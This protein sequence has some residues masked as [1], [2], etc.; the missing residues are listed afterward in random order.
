MGVQIDGAGTGCVGPAGG[1]GKRLMKCLQPAMATGAMK[2]LVATYFW[3]GLEITLGWL[4]C[5]GGR[6]APS[7]WCAPGAVA[8]DS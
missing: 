5:R 7:I 2:K 4:N 6:P 8:A 3:A 1:R